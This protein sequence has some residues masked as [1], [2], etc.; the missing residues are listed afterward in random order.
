MQATEYRIGNI[1]REIKSG[2]LLQVRSLGKESGF[3]FAMVDPSIIPIPGWHAEP[4]PLTGE[5]LVRSGFVLADFSPYY[6]KKFTAS[7]PDGE[8]KSELRINLSDHHCSVVSK[9][10]EGMIRPVKYFHELQ[11]LWYV[12]TGEELPC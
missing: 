2:E 1:L 7:Y 10:D 11:N 12:L 5:W 6:L 8:V 3:E 9:Y 4:I